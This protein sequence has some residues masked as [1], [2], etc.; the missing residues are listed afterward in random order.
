MCSRRNWL[1]TFN[2]QMDKYI[3]CVPLDSG[4]LVMSW[5]AK[6]E[7]CSNLASKGNALHYIYHF[8][9]SIISCRTDLFEIALEVVALVK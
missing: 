1:V 6:V 7:I 4:K 9:Q 8:D 5:R 3:N 2:K